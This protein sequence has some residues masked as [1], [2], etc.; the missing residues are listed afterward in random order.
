MTEGEQ[1]VDLTEL[2]L[3]PTSPTS[4]VILDKVLEPFSFS[5]L[6]CEV[7][8]WSWGVFTYMRYSRQGTNGKKTFNGY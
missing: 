8:Q 3:V 4:C 6:V 7:G 2:D 5:L 1:F